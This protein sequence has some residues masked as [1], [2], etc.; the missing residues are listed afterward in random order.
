MVNKVNAIQNIDTSDLIK[1]DDYNTE[2]DENEKKIPNHDLYI[3]TQ[4]FNKLTAEN[5]T[6]R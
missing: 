3:T 1:K 4:E 6:G 2:I 5:F